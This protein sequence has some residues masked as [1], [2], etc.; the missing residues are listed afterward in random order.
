VRPADVLARLLGHFDDLPTP[1]GSRYRSELSTIGE[2]VRVELPT[3]AT[4]E[5]AAIDV[6]GAGRLVVR[7]DDG[8]VSTFDVGDVVHVRRGENR[9]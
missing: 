8:V 3:G 9:V 2:R 6:D 1:I 5:G 4:V 7:A